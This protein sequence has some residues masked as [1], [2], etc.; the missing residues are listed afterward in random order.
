M[1]FD[2]NF[3]GWLV[4]GYMVV[5]LRAPE[6]ALDLFM[7]CL[8]TSFTRVK[9]LHGVRMWCGHTYTYVHMHLHTHLETLKCTCTLFSIHP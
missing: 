2:G 7:S 5:H 8:T 1:Y 9:L 6:K 3:L 4:V